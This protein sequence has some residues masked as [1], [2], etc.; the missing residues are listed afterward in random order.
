MV[1][2]AS[3]IL[4]SSRYLLR[5]NLFCFNIANTLNL[6]E[7]SILC[8]PI[9]AIDRPASP[10]GSDRTAWGEETLGPPNH[11]PNRCYI[12][13]VSCPASK[14]ATRIWRIQTLHLE[15]N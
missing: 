12:E 7:F 13:G 14:D 2:L 5:E 11:T 8:I 6:G 9:L 15:D 10:Q 4:T 3:V 1:T